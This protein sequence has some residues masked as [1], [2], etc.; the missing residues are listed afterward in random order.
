VEATATAMNSLVGAMT[1]RL[2]ELSRGTEAFAVAMQQVAASSQQQSASTEEIVNAAST[3]TSSAQRLSRLLANLR[4]TERRATMRILTPA[5][6]VEALDDQS[7]LSTRS[8]TS[9]I[10]SSPATV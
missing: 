3:L 2:D 1:N 10:P 6:G 5:M 8:S 7:V 9:S 4:T